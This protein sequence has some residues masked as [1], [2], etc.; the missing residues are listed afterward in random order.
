MSSSLPSQPFQVRPVILSGKVVRLEPLSLAHIP[1]L[2]AVGLDDDI[3]RYML[4]GWV[5]TEE[6]MRRWVE[7]MLALQAK[8]TDLPFAIIHLA[9][10]RAIGATRYLE[11][12][13]PDRG[14]EI[15]GTWLG[16]AYQRTAVNTESKYLLLRHA[17][18]ELG[19]IRV[20]FKTD[21]RNVRS[22]RAIERLGAV[23]EGI[24]RN[25]RILPDG[26][27]RHSIYY[28]IIAEEWPAVKRRLEG[29]LQRES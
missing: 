9:D 21:L 20:Q 22:Q 4:Y 19:C 26:T 12:R 13:P 2:C 27:I 5:R 17:F 24:F 8:G 10:G 11:I 6:D 1:D 28:S 15:G 18:E 14:L 23:K 7:S 25:H 16:K 29:Y 3:W